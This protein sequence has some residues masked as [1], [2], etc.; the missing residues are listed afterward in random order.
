M[1]RIPDLI[2]GALVAEVKS[3]RK[4]DEPPSLYTMR[5]GAGR[6]ELAQIPIPNAM[7]TMDR[8]PMILARMAA[9]VE[10][11]PFGDLLRSAAPPDLYGCAFRCEAWQVISG[12]GDSPRARE[13][14]EAAR[15]KKLYRHPDRVEVRQM[16]AVDRGG[17]TYSVTQERGS[18]EVQHLVSYPSPD[19]DAQF[20]GLIAE[21]LDGLVRGMLSVGLP[22]RPDSESPFRKR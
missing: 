18:T 6:C 3:R 7:W 1:P 10:D 11:G 15:A 5:V 20:A 19:D 2:A 21:S 9:A 17:A 8:P 4:W 13:M 16:M 22:A 14:H 12:P